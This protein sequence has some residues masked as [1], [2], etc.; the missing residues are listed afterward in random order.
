MQDHGL[1][2]IYS[3]MVLLC[4]TLQAKAEDTPQFR[5][6]FNGKDLSGWVNVNT[7]KET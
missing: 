6:I 2:L 3:A 1:K 5:D 4:G 7:D